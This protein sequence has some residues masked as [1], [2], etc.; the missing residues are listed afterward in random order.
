MQQADQ[1]LTTA[2]GRAENPRAGVAPG[3][4]ANK[5]EQGMKVIRNT[6]PSHPGVAHAEPGDDVEWELSRGCFRLIRSADGRSVFCTPEVDKDGMLR[7]TG[8]PPKLIGTVAEVK[9]KRWVLE[10]G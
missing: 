5:K 6:Y 10:V 8:K 9:N 2:S 1:N 3:P 7:S 4:P